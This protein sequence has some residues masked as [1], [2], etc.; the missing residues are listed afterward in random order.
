MKILGEKSLTFTDEIIKFFTICGIDK[1]TVRELTDKNCKVYNI[2]CS[3]VAN[4]FYLSNDNWISYR[5][6]VDILSQINQRCK[7]IN[8][9]VQISCN[10]EDSNVI[11]E[12]IKQKAKWS[13]S[14]KKITIL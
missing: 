6:I 13:S 9:Y 14:F 10:S 3:F 1:N 7:N 11:T 5:K 12:F 8:P 4:N 2:E